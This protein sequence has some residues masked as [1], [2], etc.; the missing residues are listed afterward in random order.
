[1]AAVDNIFPV[2]SRPGIQRDGTTFDSESFI[3]G[4]WCRFYR[5]K[6]QKMGG[7]NKMISCLNNVP[8][9]AFAVSNSPDPHIYVGDYESLKYFPADKSTGLATGVLTDRTPDFFNP[10]PYNQWVFD[11]MFDTSSD[12]SIIIAMAN[13]NLYSVDQTV[14]S[15]IYYGVANST[16]KFIET[17]FY[18]SGGFV[19]LPPYL[20]I[21]G[22]YGNV[23]V[24]Q[25]SDP[26]TALIENARVAGTKI[27]AGRRTRGGSNSPAG[28]LW[29][30]DSLIRVSYTGI[31]DFE[32]SFDTVSDGCS[33]LSSQSVIEYN[34]LIF[35]I[36]TDTFYMYNGAVQEWPNSM[37]L[38]YFFD[39]LNFAQRQKVWMTKYKRYGEIWIHYP[40]GNATECNKLLIY[41]VNTQEWYDSVSYRG[42]GFYSQFFGKPILLDNTPHIP[43]I[44]GPDEYRVWRHEFGVDQVVDGVPSAINSYFEM[45]VIS[46]AGTGPGGQNTAKDKT[47]FLYRFEPDFVQTGD[48]TMTVNGRAFANSIVSESAPYVFNK[49][50]VQTNY[51]EK[52][53]LKEKKRLMTLRFDSNEIGGNYKMGKCLLIPREGDTRP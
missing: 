37:S 24:T 26:T 35:W 45:S 10:N 30:L 19:V 39:N 29:S 50:P 13:Q 3:D 15:P 41:N 14:E 2:I 44:P 21:F 33:I 48:I 28:L 11:L 31:P 6:V 20:L 52:I 27:V 16:D 53:T 38:E 9:G 49:D 18:T 34:S 40:S 47:L 1:M 17:G 23:T 36:G 22:N 4:Q 43:A 51:K 42:C 25:A 8:R 12:E 5:G 7:Y 46:W 32:F